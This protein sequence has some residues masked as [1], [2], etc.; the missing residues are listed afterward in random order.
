MRHAADTL[1]RRDAPR[2]VVAMP[3]SLEGGS[4]VTCDVS[5]SGISFEADRAFALGE[6]IAF[7]LLLE[8]ADPRGPLRFC[9]RGEVVRMER[10][11]RRVRVAVAITAYRLEPAVPTGE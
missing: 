9:C 5:P 2:I 8:H 11:K 10:R 3:V 4:G 1:G 7:S 6:S